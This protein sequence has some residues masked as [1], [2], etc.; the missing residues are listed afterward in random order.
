MIHVTNHAVLRFQERVANVPAETVKAMLSAPLF[1]L[2]VSLKATAV[3]L[4]TGQ[5]VVLSGADVVT[6]LPARKR[7]HKSK[8][9]AT[10]TTWE[11]EAP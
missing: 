7:H 8:R 10:N 1:E 2:A 4:S 9:I 11:D 5:R 3:V 6:V